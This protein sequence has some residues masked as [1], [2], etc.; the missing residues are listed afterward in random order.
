M[1]KCTYCNGEGWHYSGDGTMFE[2]TPC[3]S[4][5]TIQSSSKVLSEESF[6]KVQEAVKQP[7]NPFLALRKLMRRKR[8]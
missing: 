8:G 3:N 1:D 6:G 7:A 4:S 5:G 2:C